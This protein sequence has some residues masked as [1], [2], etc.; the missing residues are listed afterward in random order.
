MKTTETIKCNCNHDYQDK[1]YGAKNRVHN[2]ALKGYR[3]A[4]GWRCTVCR[5]VKKA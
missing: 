2:Y 4:P 3:G 1:E 5:D